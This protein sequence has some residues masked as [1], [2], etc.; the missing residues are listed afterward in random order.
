LI[1]II[2]N[3]NI[4]DL[5]TERIFSR[6]LVSNWLYIIFLFLVAIVLVGGVTRMTGSGLSITE[7]K[8]IHG[9]IPPIGEIQWR[10]EFEKYQHIAQYQQANYGMK[11]AEFKHIFWWEWAHRLLARTVSFVILLPLIFFWATGRLEK[12]IKWRLLAILA[13]GAVQG[14]IG[15]WM[16]A[17]GLGDSRLTSVS[18]Y[19]LAIHLI[20]ACIIIITVLAL[21]RGLVEHTEKPAQRSIQRF[22]GWLVILI[23]F[24]IYLGALVAGLHI[25]TA[26]DILSLMNDRLIFEKLLYMRPVW[27]NFF[28]NAMT[29][30]LAHRF[31][32]YILISLSALH[33]LNVRR[34]MFKSIHSRRSMLLF[35]LVLLQAFI[36]IV[37]LFM[38][39]PIILGLMHQGVALTVLSF[40][41]AHWIGT[42][43]GIFPHGRS[44]AA[45][46]T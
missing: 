26:Y 11:L 45:C 23:L 24:Q 12:Y 15:W 2:A 4:K 41:V 7:W 6:R 20:M 19:R 29:V 35:A 10:E 8:P 25:N 18:Q 42:K 9:I 21:A 38:K 33:A 43:G 1:T 28:E 27:V 3:E 34:I 32:A 37:T 30:Q 39:V 46:H 31:F 44:Y 22:A 5:R 16:V 14:I 36:G 40:A 13:L 17:S